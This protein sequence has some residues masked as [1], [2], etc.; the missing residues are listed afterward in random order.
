MDQRATV[1][2]ATPDYVPLARE[3]Q[4]RL[5][6]KEGQLERRHFPDGERYLRILTDVREQDVVLVGGTSSDA[7][8]LDLFDVACGIVKEGCRSLTLVIPFFGYSTMERAVKAGEIV[9]A[10]T[11]AR[12]LSAIPLAP[13]GNR[14]ALLDL[15]TDG[16]TYYFEGGMVP[17]HLY[18]KAVTLQ[19][20]RDLGGT[21]DFVLGSVDAGRAKWVESLANDLGVTASIILKRRLGDRK[22]EVVA[23]SASVKGVP[24]II[25][26]DMIRTGGSLLGA[27]RAYLDAGATYVSAVTTHGLFP[28]D[29]LARIR[30]SGCIRRIICTNSHPNALKQDAA[31]GYL[32]VRSCSDVFSEF[33]LALQRRA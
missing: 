16:I 20:V 5:T 30:A 3:I 18:A 10:K 19:A 2:F 17:H 32:E 26:D 29:A 27:A 15:H 23:V 31:G 4:N 13:A 25:Y 24:V 21:G 11:R 1:V 22:T 8:T 14:V 7:A 28:D 12:L 9:T 6:L 33:L